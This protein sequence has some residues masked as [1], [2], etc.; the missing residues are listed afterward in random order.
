[1]KPIIF[2]RVADMKLYKGITETDQPANGGAFVRE[3]NYAHECFNFY[4]VMLNED[5]EHEYCLGFTQ[6]LGGQNPQLHIEHIVGCEA[7]KNEPEVHDV[8]VVF[9]SKAQNSKSMRVVGFYKHATVYRYNQQ[10][11]FPCADGTE[12]VQYYCFLAEKKD[13]VLLPYG[14]RFTDGSWFV[15]TSGKMGCSFGYGHSN[16]WFA[17]SNTENE[18]EIRYVNKMIESIE[19]YSGENMI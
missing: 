17:G 7:M 5:E 12:D 6:L 2:A 18:D 8:I 14:K 13:C 15:P 16:I 4:P 10:C 11:T 19:H 3:T 9:C 1:M